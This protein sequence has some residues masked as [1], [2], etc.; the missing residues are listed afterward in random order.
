M[1]DGVIEDGLKLRSFGSLRGSQDD[2]RGVCGT[3]TVIG[4]DWDL[5]RIDP[6]YM[7]RCSAAPIHGVALGS[8]VLTVNLN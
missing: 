4:A 8:I 6:A 7:G 5:M 2:S 3:G 1:S